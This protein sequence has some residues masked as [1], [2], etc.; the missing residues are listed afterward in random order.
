MMVD[1]GAAA[2]WESRFLDLPDGARLRLARWTS[3]PDAPRA[4]M[5]ILHGRTEFNE[6][7]GEAAEDLSRQGFAVWTFDWRGQGL[8]SR[9][10]PDRQRGHVETYDMLV[11]DL[12]A[13]IAAVKAEI[14]ALKLA[15]LAHSMGGH[16]AVR[17]LQTG[18]AAVAGAV[19]SAP[20]LGIGTERFPLWLARALSWAAVS[21]G[22]AGGYALSQRP[23][24]PG[25]DRFEGNLLTSDPHRHAVQQRW[26]VDHPEL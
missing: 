25:R 13:V 6:K 10:L 19:L 9:L 11:D 20:M 14:G 24:R 17:Y 18:A 4:A 7:Y 2:G 16:V 1:A 21:L 8:S 23:W 5:L 26:F 22:F 12:R 3:P 15:V